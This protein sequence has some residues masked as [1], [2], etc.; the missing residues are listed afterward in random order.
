MTNFGIQKSIPQLPSVIASFLLL[1]TTACSSSQPVSQAESNRN[2][3]EVKTSTLR[4][5]IISS[6]SAKLPTGPIGWAM[7]QG[8]LLPELQK[9]GIKEV[10]TF[11]FPNGP[12][13]NEALVTGELDMGIYGDTPAIVARAN[14]L[15][16]RLIS[17][18]QVG[19]NAWL[20]TRKNGA[21]SVAELKG[22]KVATS[23][24]SY[25]HRYVI[26]LLQKSG[27]VDQVKV[28]H[29]LPNEAQAALER[30]DV[31]AIAAPTGT[32]PLLQSKGFPVIDEAIKHPD[33]PG[34][35]VTIATEAFLAQHPDLPQKWNQIKQAAVKSIKADPEGYYKFHAQ[36][37][38]Y[39]VNVV[40][41]SLSIEQFPEE[42]I[43]AKGIQLLQGTKQ[44]LIS[45]KLAKSDF[46]LKDWIVAQK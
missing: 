11:S 28:V 10:Q 13:L 23:K 25:M 37:S 4:L 14:G 36:V 5:G 9:L 19:T 16:T 24:G 26:G 46:E 41:A 31:A 44:F 15:P 8:K 42:P 27:V 1:L 45:Q 39:S 29:L 21:H 7:H 38:G 18:E 12:N 40:K 2:P 32:G 6:K 34:T 20:V 3:P 17:Q 30:G 35:S 22:Q 33:L 43:P